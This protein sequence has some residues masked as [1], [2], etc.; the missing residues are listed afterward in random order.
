VSAVGHYLEDE[1]IPT[2][3][4]S[5]VREHSEVMRPPRAL[6]VPFMLGRPL[7]APNSPQ[8]QRTVLRAVLALFERPSG[9]VLEDFPHDAP[10]S[11]ELPPDDDGSGEACPVLFGRPRTAGAPGLADALQEEIAQLRP[12]HDLGARRRGGSGVGIS[13][14]SPEQAG[15]FVAA[16]LGATPPANPRP[17]QPLGQT[18]KFAVDDLRAF[19][20]E[21]AA[22]QPGELSAAALQ[23]WFYLETVVGE[24]LRAARQAA[25]AGPDESV[26]LVAERSLVPRAM[27]QSAAG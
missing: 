24:V 17:G 12:W 18:L 16:F 22:V 2:A 15:A 21:A 6:W 25:L 1:G 7:G 26:R 3:G 27:L 10:A 9:P 23:R 13:G 20:E 8:F 5:L 11:A 4:I 19:Y 14:L